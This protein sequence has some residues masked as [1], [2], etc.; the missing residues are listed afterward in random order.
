MIVVY[1]NKKLRI[2][3]PQITEVNN[4]LVKTIKTALG[5]YKNKKQ[6]HTLSKNAMDC[7][8]SWKKSAQ[9]YVKLYNKALEKK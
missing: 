3:T 8:F 1:P 9:E 7:D 6:W 2:K 4:Q 5:V